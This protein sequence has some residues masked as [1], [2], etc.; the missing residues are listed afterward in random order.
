[1]ENTSPV[2]ILAAG[3]SNR[4]GRPKAF[5]EVA[6]KTLLLHIVERFQKLNCYPIVVVT[7]QDCLFQATLES[8][9]STVVLNSNP[10][11]GR[12][13]SIQLGLST[14]INEIGRLPERIIIAPVDRPG[15]KIENITPLLQSEISSSLF[16]NGV[17]GHP[18]TI[19]GK[20][21]Q[22]LLGADKSKPL[23]DV[24]VFGQVDVDAPLLS[25]NIDTPEDIEILQDNQTFFESINP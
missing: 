25:L 13:G 10:K 17:K 20:D 16:S 18:V 15:W 9:E 1:M 23:R 22:T 5:V 19:V 2:V 24:I 6:G 21:L 8:K 4:L 7:N 12:T 14:I 3:A 11:L